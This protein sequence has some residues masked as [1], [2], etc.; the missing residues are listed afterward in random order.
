MVLK[1]LIMNYF[2]LQSLDT[3]LLDNKEIAELYED[4]LRVSN[5]VVSVI[6]ESL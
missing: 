5:V 6:N 3:C 4:M 2:L 1:R